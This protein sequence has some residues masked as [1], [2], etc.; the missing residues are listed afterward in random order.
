MERM[1]LLASGFWIGGAAA[2]APIAGYLLA[3]HV[4]FGRRHV[5]FCNGD[6]AR[7][8]SGDASRHGG[9]THPLPRLGDG[10]L[11]RR[12]CMLADGTPETGDAGVLVR[13]NDPGT[14]MTE[15]DRMRLAPL[16]AL[17]RKRRSRK[18][19]KPEPVAEE[20]LPLVQGARQTVG[21]ALVAA[22]AGDT[23]VEKQ[24]AGEDYWLDP[25]TLA[26]EVES[27]RAAKSRLKRYQRKEAKDAFKTQKLKEEI[28]APYKNNLIGLAVLAVGAAAVVFSFFP[29]L[30]ELPD[31][32]DPKFPDVL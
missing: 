27:Q 28:A 11:Q 15:R 32:A 1:L 17:K 14:L 10:E 4:R 21:E 25:A 13:P 29:D 3:P 20:M 5:R 7:S 31:I 23:I 30:L 22:Y 26:R 12:V 16:H 6:D 19:R 8:G 18:I 9:A 2:W 24:K